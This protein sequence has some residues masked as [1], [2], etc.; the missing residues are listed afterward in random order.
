MLKE[1]PT[2]A[3]FVHLLFLLFYTHVS[4][5]CQTATSD[6]C[7]DHKDFV[8]G[9]SL[10]GA[11]FDIT[12]L[13]RMKAKVLDM[14][15]WEKADGTCTLCQN[16]LLEGK[17]LQRLPLAI[18]DWE[19]KVT[20]RRNVRTSLLES[21]IS[22]VQEAGSVVQNDWKVGLD[23]QLK[24]QA[25]VQVALAGSHSKMADFSVQKSSQD[26]Y[27]FVSHEISCSHY[28]FRI[29]HHWR[30]TEHFKLA[31]KNLPNK[32]QHTTRLEYYQLI[33]T[34]GTHLITHLHLGGRMKDV[35]AMRVCESV[36]DEV[37]A[38][39]VKDCLSL[40]ASA[41]IGVDKAKMDASYKTC[42]ELKKKRNFKGSFHKT[43]RER[44][45]EIVGGSSH[46]DLLFSD[47]QNAEAFKE[48]LEGL[49]SLPDMLSY[50]LAPIHILVP[51]GNKR[52]A[53]QKAVSEYVKERALWRNC[54]HPCPPG[55]T[56]SPR[57][58]CSCVCHSNG[59]TNSMCCSRKWGQ[60]KL[61]VTIQRAHNL[62][63]DHFTHT[64]AYVKVFY[65]GKQSQ[66]STI[67]NNN[68][69]VWNVHLDFGIIQ[70]L[71]E[72]SKVK[73]QVWDED[74]RYDD[75]LLGS[76]EKTLQAGKP[77]SEV[78]YFTHG[79]LN[80]QYHL[81]CGNYLGGPYC[82]DYVPETPKYV[83]ALLQRKG[84]ADPVTPKAP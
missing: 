81:I 79:N 36:L 24:P 76:C 35:T 16:P 58:P 6:Q 59:L 12:K 68:N 63:G 2:S 66:T 39:E 61:T 78:C 71:G 45:T 8:P 3:A 60:G 17:P 43:Y 19:A 34:Y 10:A 14:N 65:Q 74:N 55:T 54:T 23:V 15:H 52:E 56:R 29:G 46:T 13:E 70:V 11:G 47:G 77:Q 26:K 7:Q 25:N 53:L 44:Q 32:Y 80:F 40:E 33:G 38:D 73:V 51:K 1:N 75:D 5:Q 57:D 49:K 30:L 27:T 4:P 42:E 82:L 41:S 20:C 22:V 9:Y 21:G 67:W 64:D 18:A 83:G 37:T 84:K 69:P 28:S 50:S 62:W 72:S 48:W 31:L